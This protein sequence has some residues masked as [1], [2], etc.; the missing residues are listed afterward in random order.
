MHWIVAESHQFVDK[1]TVLRLRRELSRTLSKPNW[2]RP[3]LFS[4]W[5][6]I[7]ALS[8]L[9]LCSGPPFDYAQGPP[10][11]KLRDHPSVNSG[12]TLPD[13][14]GDHPSAGLGTSFR[15]C[16]K[17]YYICR[18]WNQPAM[19]D[20]KK[21]HE[22]PQRQTIPWDV[23]PKTKPSPGA[24][25]RLEP[26]RYRSSKTEGNHRRGRST[27]DFPNIEYRWRLLGI[28][29]RKCS[30]CDCEYVL[31]IMPVLPNFG[32]IHFHPIEKIIELH[33]RRY[34]AVEKD[35]LKEK[36]EMVARM[37][38]LLKNKW[39]RHKVTFNR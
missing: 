20:R 37:E 23:E 28:L 5:N 17:V 6:P 27:T 13:K 26:A 14:L 3:P 11:D 35:W 33:D 36:D 31:G 12:T 25:R 16:V 34:G 7:L 29:M 22:S 39:W 15:L 10:F 32:S 2:G 24:G 4:L 38:R 21:V 19:S 9:R 30:E 1:R 8:T 18:S